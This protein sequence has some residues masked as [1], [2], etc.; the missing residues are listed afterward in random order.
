VPPY[1][2]TQAYV[3][4][5]MQFYEYFGGGV[6]KLAQIRDGRVRLALPPRRGSLPSAGTLVPGLTAASRPVDVA[7]E[8]PAR[9]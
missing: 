4:L 7:G 3:K 5:V 6:K 2:E 8:A 1:P 9:P